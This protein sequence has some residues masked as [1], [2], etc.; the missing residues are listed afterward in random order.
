MTRSRVTATSQ[1]TVP[2]AVR[3]ALQ[4]NPGDCLEYL[5]D[6]SN[7]MLRKAQSAGPED[8]F[9]QFDEWSSEG[10]CKAYASF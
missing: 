4:V 8:P 5:I 7:V 1:T 10:D 6:G 2:Q 9:A 3:R